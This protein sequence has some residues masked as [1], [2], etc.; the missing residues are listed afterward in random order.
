MNYKEIIIDKFRKKHWEIIEI[1]NL[2]EWW[3]DEHWKIQWKH[4]NGLILYVQFLVDP[5]DIPNVWQIQAKLDIE[6]GSSE[7]ASLSMSK[8]KFNIKLEEFI[9]EIENYRKNENKN[10]KQTL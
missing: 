8:R 3:E 1:D 5:M 7:I 2:G 10:T 6:K 4:N 9:V